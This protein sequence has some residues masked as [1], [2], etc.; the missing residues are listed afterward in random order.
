[1]EPLP[2][3]A[4]ADERKRYM[5]AR[6]DRAEVEHSTPFALIEIVSSNG[7]RATLEEIEQAQ[8]ST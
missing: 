6:M 2:T 5:S 7:M 4:R 1:V 8:A 3:D